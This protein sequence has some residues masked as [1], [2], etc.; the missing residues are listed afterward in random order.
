MSGRRSPASPRARRHAPGRARRAVAVLAAA[1]LTAGTGVVALSVGTSPAVAATVSGTVVGTGSNRCLTAIGTANAARVSIATCTGSSAQAW[2]IGDGVARNGASGRCLSIENNAKSDGAVVWMYGCSGAT[3]QQWALRGDGSLV[4]AASGKCLD[5]KGKA[6]TDGA[7][8]QLYGCSGATNQKWTVKG[9]TTAPAAG[10]VVGVGSGKCLTQGSPAVIDT[11]DGSPG[12]K[13]RIAA[14]KVA[15]ADGA[16]CLTAS[17]TANGSVVSTVA[18]SSAAAQGWT[19]TSAGAL[20]NTASKRCADVAKQATADGSPV[21]LWD[22]VGSKTNQLWKLGPALPGDPTDP[23]PVIAPDPV[24]APAD[25]VI[26]VEANGATQKLKRAGLGSLFGVSSQPRLDTSLVTQTQN[27]LSQHQSRL[28]DASYPSSTEAV[29]DQLRGTDV[30]MDG[31]YNDLVPGFPYQWYGLDKW[32]ADVDSATRSVQSYRDELY[33]VAPF[34]EP[35]NKFKG[36]FMTDPKLEGSTYDERVNNLWVTTVR[37][38]RAIDPTIPILGPN[39]EFWNLDKMRA[40]LEKTIATGT[41]PQ[42]IGWHS[43]GPSPG[44]V[45]YALTQ[46]RPLERELGVPGAPLPLSVEEYGPGTG[47]FEGVPGTMVKHWA[48]FAR[49][50]VDYASQGIYTNDGLLGNTLRRVYG[51]SPQPNGGWYFQRW[52]KQMP[53]VQVPVSSWRDRFYQAS[54]GVAAWD[55]ASKTVT[56]VAGGQDGEVDVRFNG[57][58]ARGLGPNVRVRVEMTRWDTDPN[59]TDKT[60]ENGGDR[61]SGTYSLLDRNYRLDSAGGIRVPV[62]CMEGY[63]GYRILVSPVAAPAAQATKYE[64]ES[65]TL[66]SATPHTGADSGLASGTG[67]VGGLDRSDSAVAFS[68]NAPSTGLYDMTVRYSNPGSAASTQNVSVD[69]GSQGSVAYQ[70]T[71]TGATDSLRTVV[72]RLALTAGRHTVKLSHATGAPELDFVDVRPD[73]FRYEAEYYKVTD[74]RLGVF[75]YNFKPGY[76]GGIDQADSSVEIPVDAPKAGTYRLDIGYSNRTGAPAT[77]TVRVNGA[78][79]GS[80]S[81]A[82]TTGWFDT[83]VQDQVE[84]QTSVTVTLSQGVNRVQ[85]GKGTGNAEL[86]FVNLVYTGS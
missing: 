40:F 76:V 8:V 28:G 2:T 61:Q 66:T 15:G 59:A 53:G 14:G 81:Y 71:G 19:V 64:A 9:S 62:H 70:S 36:S 4:N 18:C 65:A 47:D 25:D 49:N 42:V 37:R 22:C 30:L 60:V 74:A 84:K 43:L 10:T 52:Y 85:L 3:G 31:R 32:L 67:W 72:K 83:A 41:T 12:Q 50:G 38:I 68:V 1:V 27:V 11:C 39:Y 13:W 24:A 23:T 56:M 21:Q 16:L 63:S 78:G 57:L 45:P 44:D 6:T 51:S 86:D 20:V 58:A 7:F 82:T 26:T 5:V 79:Q 46:Y 75:R 55:A 34:N 69:G 54:D 73:L 77:H 29:A 48:E 35:D 17:G 80:A 33:A